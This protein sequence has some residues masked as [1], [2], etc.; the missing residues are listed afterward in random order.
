MSSTAD[1][2]ADWPARSER[3]LD[4]GGGS[5]TFQALFEGRNKPQLIGLFL[6]LLELIRQKRLRAVQ[7]STRRQSAT[8]SRLPERTR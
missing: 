4:R 5:M 7:P 8:A 2:S 6:A 1:G 3:G